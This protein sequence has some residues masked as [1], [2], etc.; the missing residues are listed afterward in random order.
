MLV[1][2]DA[3]C[4]DFASRKQMH[5]SPPLLVEHETD[6]GKREQLHTHTHTQRYCMLLHV[7]AC[8]L[9]LQGFHHELFDPC[10]SLSDNRT[11]IRVRGSHPPLAIALSPGLGPSTGTSEGQKR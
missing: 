4:C 5:F 3:V 11:M 9:S 6:T 7:A 1:V 2:R 10:P 8:L